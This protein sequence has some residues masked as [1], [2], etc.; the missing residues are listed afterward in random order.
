LSTFAS[1]SSKN[2]LT[3][4]EIISN[5]TRE[6]IKFDEDN[7]KIKITKISVSVDKLSKSECTISAKITAKLTLF[8]TGV[9][10]ELKA[11]VTAS[12]CS[13]ASRLAWQGVRDAANGLQ[14]AMKW[15]ETMIDSYF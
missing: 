11:S 12:T 4:K 10:V 15:I 6:I 1:S 8:G 7:E 13:E 3:E 2:D 5:V 14:N 9:E